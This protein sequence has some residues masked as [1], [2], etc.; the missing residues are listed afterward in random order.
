MFGDRRQRDLERLGEIGHP[1]LSGGQAGEDRPPGRV[2]ERRKDRVE[3]R[4]C[5]RHSDVSSHAAFGR[6]ADS[7]S[8]SAW[9]DGRAWTRATYF[10]SF[11]QR[12]ASTP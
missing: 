4:G 6:P 11:G 12:A 8:M 2:R 7:S 10:A 9:N 5:R 3:V 1:G